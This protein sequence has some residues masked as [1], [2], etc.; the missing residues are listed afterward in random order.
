MS[1]HYLQASPRL[2]SCLTSRLLAS[3]SRPQYV[4]LLLAAY[5]LAGVFSY[6]PNAFTKHVFSLV[7][8]VWTMQFVF[9][10]QWIHSFAS[11]AIS[12]ILVLILPNR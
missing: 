9:H 3:S 12:Y 10:S 11:S 8:G 2:T 1:F 6:L 4:L 5:P 7:M